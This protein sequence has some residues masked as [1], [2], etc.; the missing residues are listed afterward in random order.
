MLEQYTQDLVHWIQ[1]LPPISIYLVFLVIAYTE[2]I[3]PPIPGDLLVAFGGYL[4]AESIISGWI[5][6]LITTVASVAG[7][8]TMYWLGSYW[9]IGIQQQKK[10]FWLT[11]FIS[12]RYIN[13]VRN[14]MRRWGQGVIVAN[15]FL[16]GTRSVISLT[17]GISH[18]PIF[19]TV[20]SSTVS[21]I[22]WNA[23]LLGF[24]WIVHENW[25]II[26]DYLS[27]YGRIVLVL[28]GVRIA[29]RVLMGYYRKKYR[30]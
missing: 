15:R 14:W 6:L 5:V 8:M 16:A 12:L 27:V 18:T 19:P 26:G 22:L 30:N 4:A 28:L 1:A 9:G 2:N 23:I 20:V 25:Q 13:K 17:A 29:G 11:R 21:S 3:L 7:F 10:E 24:G